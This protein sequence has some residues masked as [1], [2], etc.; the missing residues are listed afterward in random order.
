VE[1][2]KLQQIPKD[3]SLQEIVQGFSGFNHPEYGH[4]AVWDVRRVESMASAF[5]DG[6]VG[7]CD[8]AFWDTRRVVDMACMFKGAKHFN[9]NISNWDTR[10]VTNMSRMFEGAEAFNGDISEWNVRAVRTYDSVFDGAIAMK[11][12]HKPEKFRETKSEFGRE[13]RAYV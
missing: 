2:W 7:L 4:I 5:E 3:A 6:N 13:S 12:N 10:N 8:M 11:E 9:G 1:R